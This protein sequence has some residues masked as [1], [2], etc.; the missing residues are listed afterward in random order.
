MFRFASTVI[1]R[2]PLMAGPKVAVS[3]LVVLDVEPG[4]AAG[5]QLPSVA[6][7]PSPSR[8]H[9]AFAAWATGERAVS[10]ASPAAPKSAANVAERLAPHRAFLWMTG[11][12]ARPRCTF[13]D[14]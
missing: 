12:T 3:G 14:M 5:F 9:V 11:R 6:H 1:A 10:D 4:T 2:A 13:S 7:E 8:V